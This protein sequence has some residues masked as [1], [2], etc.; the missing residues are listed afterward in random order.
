MNG[1]HVFYQYYYKDN[2]FNLLLEL[3]RK[4]QQALISF[5]FSTITNKILFTIEIEN[6]VTVKVVRTELHTS[7]LH[8]SSQN[9]AE[10]GRVCSIVLQRHRHSQIKLGE[11]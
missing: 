6:K 8:D 10:F 1:V 2:T 5:Q 7:N 11:G 3:L 4:D 9:T